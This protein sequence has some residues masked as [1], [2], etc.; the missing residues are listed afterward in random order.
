V[1]PVDLAEAARLTDGTL[2]GGANPSTEVAGPVVVDSRQAMPGALFVCL[3]GEHVDGHDFA[4]TAVAAG[5]VAALAEHDVDAPAVVV[6][7]STRALGRLAAG[8]LLRAGGCTVVGVTGSS[9]KTSTKD[10][11]AH[12]LQRQGPV[13]APRNSFNNE[14]GLPLTVLEVTPQTRILVCEYSARGPGHIAYLSTIAPPRIAVVLNVGAAHLGEFGSRDAVAAAKSE[15]VAALPE[16]GTAVLNADDPRVVAMAARTDAPIVWFGTGPDVDVR[17]VDLQLD[18]LAR[19]RFRLV[20]RDGEVHVSLPLS[21]AHHAQNAAAATGAAL[22][23]GMN[24]VEIAEALSTAAP[25]SAHRMGVF[26]RGDD[27]LIV[28]DAYNANPESMRAALEA[29]RSMAGTRRRWAVLGEMRE[30]GAEGDELHRDVGRLVARTG[31]DELLVVSAAAQAIASGAS[32]VATWSG[33]GRIVNDAE[34]AVSVLRA[35]LCPGDAVLV[36][37]S[38]GVRLWRVAEALVNDVPAG[39]AS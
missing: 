11:L 28:D 12:V 10:L 16:D 19:A 23:S 39:A 27:V 34:A 17:V 29:F 8:V 33:R 7:D 22:A 32:D 21:G 5:A 2:S 30:L 15:L 9:G 36:K 1:I 37:A 31:V 26:Q 25:R 14:I 35:E 20:T 18:G 38:N 24:L 4:A 6:P 13:V 3:R